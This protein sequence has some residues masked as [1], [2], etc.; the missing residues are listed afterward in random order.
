MDAI[1]AQTRSPVPLRGR[2]T[3]RHVQSI[4]LKQWTICDHEFFQKFHILESRSN[5]LFTL[6]INFK[7]IYVVCYR[8]ERPD[9][10]FN[11]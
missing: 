5:L 7:C 3:V 11:E 9:K 6:L 2:Y 1:L 10:L 4:L 8:I